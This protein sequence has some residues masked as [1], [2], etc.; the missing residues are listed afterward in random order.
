MNTIVEAIDKARDAVEVDDNMF[1]MTS[2]LI[3]E[4]LD[5][6]KDSD[7]NR[8]ILDK[9]RSEVGKNL[10]VSRRPSP[11]H[12]PAPRHVRTKL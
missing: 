9:H 6:E 11:P 10:S 1:S 5:V 7:E 8:R 4:L 2:P 12:P 3:D